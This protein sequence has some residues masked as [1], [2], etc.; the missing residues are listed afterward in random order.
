MKI[1][2]ITLILPLVLTGILR[3]AE[4][5]TLTDAQEKEGWK[6]LFDGKSV[7]GWI[8]WGAHKPLDDTS[9][10]KVKDGALSITAK[11]AGD[12]YTRDAFEN[13]ELWMEWK[14]RGNSGILFRVDPS[15]R[16]AIWN[17]APEMQVNRENNPKNLRSTS[18][19]GLYQLYNLEGPEKI[20]HADDWNSVRVILKNDHATFW[21]NGKKAYEL[22]FGSEEWKAR[23]AKSKFRKYEGFAG[24]KKGHIGLQDH[25]AP[26]AY[27]NIRIKVLD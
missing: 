15:H 24:L 6:L 19:G 2:Y 27:R 25:G 26:V 11:G 18:A 7:D 5:N 20:V 12:I 3:A 9:K 21:F 16:G 17:K 10:W 13:Y 8:R 1:L 22:T 4:P 23:V 14:S